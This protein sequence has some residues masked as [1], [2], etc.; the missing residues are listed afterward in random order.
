MRVLQLLRWRLSSSIDRHVWRDFLSFSFLLFS[1]HIDISYLLVR[2][3]QRISFF[4]IV[5]PSILLSSSATCS[6]LHFSFTR[7]K[8]CMNAFASRTSTSPL[9]NY[10][11]SVYDSS[12]ENAKKLKRKGM[13][14]QGKRRWRVKMSDE[15]CRTRQNADDNQSSVIIDR[16]AGDDGKSFLSF[17]LHSNNN[18]RNPFK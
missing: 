2:V 10:C 4:Y 11:L 6:L 16:R 7:Y 8:S 18:N 9:S 1:Q 13:R 15:R 12:I 14:V 5:T 3:V 17:S